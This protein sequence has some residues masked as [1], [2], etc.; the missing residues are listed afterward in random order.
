M[1]CAMTTL[2]RDGSRQ[3]STIVGENGTAR[4]VSAPPNMFKPTFGPAGGHTRERKLCVHR[5]ESG[6]RGGT[7]G[8]SGGRGGPSGGSGDQRQF[9]GGKSM[10]VLF[11]QRAKGGG[12]MVRDGS[13]VLLGRGVRHG[14]VIGGGARGSSG[15]S[16]PWRADSPPASPQ[17]VPEQA[18]QD[19]PD[20][21][22][23]YPKPASAK[24]RAGVKHRKTKMAA[25]APPLLYQESGG[26]ITKQG[27]AA[28][29]ESFR[30]KTGRPPGRKNRKIRRERNGVGA[31]RRREKEIAGWA[32]AESLNE[33][34]NPVAAPRNT[35]GKWRARV[36]RQ[37]FDESG[38]CKRM[39][40]PET[41]EQAQVYLWTKK[42]VCM[43]NDRLQ[44]KLVKLQEKAAA[45]EGIKELAKLIWEDEPLSKALDPSTGCQTIV[46]SSLGWLL[47]DLKA[48]GQENVSKL[49]HVPGIWG[50]CS[51]FLKDPADLPPF[52]GFAAHTDGGCGEDNMLGED[53]LGAQDGVD[54]DDTV[55]G[56]VAT[57]AEI[58]MLARVAASRNRRPAPSVN[59][60]FHASS[61]AGVLVDPGMNMLVDVPDVQEVR[62][63]QGV[64]CAGMGPAAFQQFPPGMFQQLPPGMLQQN[65]TLFGQ[66]S[67]PSTFV[68]ASAGLALP[69]G[70]LPGW[71]PEAP[72]SVG[73]ASEAAIQVSTS[74]GPALSAPIQVVTSVGPA[75]EVPMQVPAPTIP[76][77][78]D[79]TSTGNTTEP[80][81]AGSGPDLTCSENFADV[82]PS[83]G[84]L[85]CFE[86]G[87][88][89][90][91][92]PMSLAELLDEGGSGIPV[93]QLPHSSEAGVPKDSGRGG[94][95]SGG[96]Q[97]S[98]G[99]AGSQ[100]I[101]IT[102]A[103]E[104]L[105]ELEGGASAHW[106]SQG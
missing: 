11:A 60:R 72:T 36:T 13:R 71:V 32:Y 48:R 82:L 46:E 70:V 80:L 90:W 24:S 83:L 15:G 81:G 56:L 43:V 79:C 77:S 30:K 85:P 5:D 41:E 51:I 22:D 37:P 66:P 18:D 17:P 61:F 87:C 73:P 63:G 49:T 84:E 76:T 34:S 105:L 67:L 52:Y 47:D 21:S 91:P 19:D 31:I 65:Q 97:L 103:L 14:D 20:D 9:H 55:G 92:N 2:S 8:G 69:A 68:A 26:P 10:S 86:Q 27:E 58:A 1:S 75:S 38:K 3:P 12:G 44:H 106:G 62:Q 39:L 99:Y 95:G 104:A 53:L 29:L 50:A 64:V 16:L 74:V 78:F 33:F 23:Y 54:E 57:P 7:S 93:H 101:S 28:P 102:E 35:T 100:P 94:E 6:R 88:L 98:Q 96:E 4:R 42:L 45:K 25:L 89:A 40:K 59:P